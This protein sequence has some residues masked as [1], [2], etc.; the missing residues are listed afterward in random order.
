MLKPLICPSCG[1]KVDNFDEY[2]QTAI[3][4]YC[5]VTLEDV[6]DLQARY[7]VNV[8]VQDI[9]SPESLSKRGFEFLRLGEYT[10]AEGNFLQA[11]QSDTECFLAY[12]GEAFVANIGNAEDT[13]VRFYLERATELY[14]QAPASDRDI[15]REAMGYSCVDTALPGGHPLLERVSRLKMPDTEQMLVDLGA[16]RERLS[17]YEDQAER[18]RRKANRQFVVLLVSPFILVILFFALLFIDAVPVGVKIAVLLAGIIVFA[19]GRGA[20]S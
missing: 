5:G 19:F 16:S 8:H 14:G 2:T 12:L 9:P 3:C 4:P 17:Q 10:Q 20:A 18:D 15:A 11:M 7:E 6:P 13:K 1:A